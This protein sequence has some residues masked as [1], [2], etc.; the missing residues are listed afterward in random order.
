MADSKDG[1]LGPVLKVLF[2]EAV[3]FVILGAALML[4]YIEAIEIKQKVTDIEASLHDRVTDEE[5]RRA[6]KRFDTRINRL[7]T[8]NGWEYLEVSE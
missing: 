3:R 7:Y 5:F 6:V 4:L 2:G 1:L 8:V